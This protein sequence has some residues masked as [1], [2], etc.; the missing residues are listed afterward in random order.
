M[1]TKLFTIAMMVALMLTAMTKVQAQNYD[2]PCLPQSHGLVG[3]QSAL[4]GIIQ[5]IAMTG[6]VNWVSFYVETTLDDLK[7]ALEA[8]GG[9][10]IVIQAKNG[11][12]T[13]NGRR[14]LGTVSGFSLTQMYKIHVA[15]D[16]EIALEG[17]PLNPAELTITINNGANW[18]GFPFTESMTLS[19]AFAGFPANQ[20]AVAS[21]S[22]SSTWNGR[23]WLGLLNTLVPGQGYIYTSAATESKEF[24]YPTSS[25][26]AANGEKALL[27]SK[28]RKSLDG[29]RSISKMK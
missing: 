24:T 22:G 8:T 18:I 4:C 13:W 10:N 28:G 27:K 16:C 3:H 23:R 19:D 26:K 25:S 2:G 14:W 21:K 17:M 1:K 15:A 5:T 29:I 6:G 11:S 9:T 20:D 7:A 12:T